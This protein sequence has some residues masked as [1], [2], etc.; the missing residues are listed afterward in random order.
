MDGRNRW[1]AIRRFRRATICLTLVALGFGAAWAAPGPAAVSG[2]DLPRKQMRVKRTDD[3]TITG[4]GDAAAWAAVPW[5]VLAKRP[6]PGPERRTRA[7]MLYSSTGLYVLMD[8]EDR[9][10]TATIRKDFLDLWK[11]DVL[12]VFLWPDERHPLYFEYEISP[13][14]YELP[15]LIPN[16]D[17][18]FLGWRPWHYE[19]SRLIRKAVTITGGPQ[20]P[21][22]AIESWKAEFFIPY[23]LLKPLQNVPPQAGSRWRANFYRMDYDN[24]QAS[25]WDWARVGPS[26]HEYQKFGDLI[27]E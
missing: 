15:I 12:E 13:L 7:K 5:T 26:F 9:R 23:E 3:F 1:L 14:G 21:G 4:K 27:F 11:E 24:G 17:G 22:A 10:L 2:Q 19:G 20:K 16:F 18:E 6:G 25:A 8:A